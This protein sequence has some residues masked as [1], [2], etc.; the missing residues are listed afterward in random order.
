L[1]AIRPQRKGRSIDLVTVYRNLPV[2]ETSGIICRSDFSDETA[3]FVLASAE[4]RHH[5]HHIVCRSCHR[6]EAV[7]FC[8]IKGQEKILTKLGFRDIHHRLEF[9]GICRACTKS[10]TAALK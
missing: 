3:R 4:H 1:Q 7:D 6:V 5:H 2:F 10:A 8:A 9:S